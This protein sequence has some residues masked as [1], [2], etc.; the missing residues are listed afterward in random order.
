MSYV[1][2][3][4]DFIITGKRRFESSGWLLTLVPDDGS[5]LPPITP[6]QFVELK[7][8]NASGVTLR[9][10]ISVCDVRYGR[11]LILYIKPVGK[12]TNA[13]CDLS[14][15]AKVNVLFPLGHGFS[16]ARNVSKVLLV[17]G[18]V[19]CAPLV[20]LARKLDE[21]GAKVVVALGGRS[22]TELVDFTSM[23]SGLGTLALSTDDG[24]LGH[25]GLITANPAF[26]EHYDMVYV[27]GPTPMMKAVA[28]ICDERHMACEVSLEN[29]MACGL[30]ACLCCVEKTSDAGNVCVCTEGPVFNIN[31]LKTWL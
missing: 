25:P 16:L 27:C 18:G 10:P 8:D 20:L 7:V 2:E 5:W 12:G 28:K 26:N 21:A 31:R 24:S 6:G 13:L 11:E 19:G 3:L 15:G 14:I 22:A 23:F 9:R 4:N 30:G 17:G 29:H 1:K